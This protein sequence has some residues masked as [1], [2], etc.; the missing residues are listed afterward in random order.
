MRSGG[1]FGASLA[2][3][4]RRRRWRE[5]A[6]WLAAG[7]QLALGAEV[8]QALGLLRGTFD[9]LDLVALGVGYVVG[10]LL[11]GLPARR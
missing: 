10:V 4:W 2:L 8:G 3:V 9:V 5:K 1:A 7:G 6:P 11:A